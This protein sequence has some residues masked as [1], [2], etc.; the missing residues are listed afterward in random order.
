MIDFVIT[1]TN[2]PVDCDPA[3]RLLRSAIF[4]TTGLASDGAI[5]LPEGLDLARYQENPI[6]TDRHLRL[7]GQPPDQSAATI[8]NAVALTRSATELAAEVEFADTRLGRDFAYLYGVNEE[9]RPY[10]RAWSIEGNFLERQAVSWDA[11]R[12]ISGPYWDEPLAEM[13]RTQGG[14]PSVCSRFLLKSV[15]AVC[16][17]ADRNALTRADSAGCALAGE[18]VSRI[19]LQLAGTELADVKT[20]LGRSNERIDR[21][22]REIQALRGEG[23]SAAAQGDSEAILAAVRELAEICR[24]GYGKRQA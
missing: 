2:R 17:G 13:L 19:D 23:A 18:L 1:A 8:G 24:N 5:I 9:K 22:E 3:K 21:L 10:M 11:A 16:T 14:R 15:A 7:P 20:Q 12:K 4:L 6:V